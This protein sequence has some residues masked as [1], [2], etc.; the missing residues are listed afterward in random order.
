VSGYAHFK[1]LKER[2]NLNGNKPP[3]YTTIRNIIQGADPKGLE[4]AFR[5]HAN[6]LK[7][8]DSRSYIQ[9]ALDG[10]TVKGSFDHFNDHKAI[11]V[12][13]AFL[14]SQQIIL[15]HEMIP[16]NKTNG[17]KGIPAFQSLSRNTSS[18]SLA[19]KGVC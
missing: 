16:D 4:A 18:K 17:L 14:T 9:V 19:L 15:G 5:T 3:G 11:Q 10:K 2:F 6:T 8:L 12:F 13:S 7:N 1:V